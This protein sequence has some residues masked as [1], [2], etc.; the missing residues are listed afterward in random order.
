MVLYSGKDLHMKAEY[1]FGWK[2]LGKEMRITETLGINGVSKIDNVPAIEIYKKYLNIEPNKFL[3]F[4]VFDFPFI[5]KRGGL[6][7]SRIAAIYDEEGR[8]FMTGDVK[9]GEKTVTLL[10]G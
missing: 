5:V 7:A 10:F 4:N 9:Q 1:N 2:P 3:I 8:L 6:N